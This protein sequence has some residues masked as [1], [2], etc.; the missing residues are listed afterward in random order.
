MDSLAEAIEDVYRTFS[1]VPVPSEI[2][3]CPCCMTAEEVEVLLAKPL[4][5]LTP[6][7]LSSYSSSALLTVGDVSDYL[8]YLPRI[9][10]ISIRDDAWWP[11]I[12]VSAKK[13]KMTDPGSWTPDR[14]ETLFA[15]FYVAISHFVES[16]NYERLDDC[17]CAVAAMDFE[18]RPFLALIETDPAAVLEYFEDNA[19]CLN[20]GKLCN[21]FWE[22][23]NAGHDE[24]VKWF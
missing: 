21:A 18:V 6:A 13:I 20:Q 14:R 9:L 8:Y 12:E 15:F 17:M 16:K 23:P 22:L 2:A 24:I 1:D 10:E 19:K 11:D 7:E 3:A 4:P 5:E